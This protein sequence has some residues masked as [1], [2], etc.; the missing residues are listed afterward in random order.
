M[1]AGL[2]HAPLLPGCGRVLVDATHGPTD[3][4]LLGSGNVRRQSA[5]PPFNPTEIPIGWLEDW[6]I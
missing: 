2:R 6:R 4:S 1:A 5:G 3:Q